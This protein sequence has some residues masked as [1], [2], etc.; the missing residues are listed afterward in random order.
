MGGMDDDEE[1]AEFRRRRES[2]LASLKALAFRNIAVGDDT[3]MSASTLDARIVEISILVN[4]LF[5]KLVPGG[6]ALEWTS[7]GTADAGEAACSHER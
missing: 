1:R 5:R 3:Q 7:R 4:D 6:I 2:A